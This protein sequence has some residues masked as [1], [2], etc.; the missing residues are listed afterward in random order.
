MRK[1]GVSAIATD[2][3]CKTNTVMRKKKQVDVSV[4]YLFMVNLQPTNQK[5][6]YDKKLLKFTKRGSGRRREINFAKR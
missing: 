1:I 5:G 2:C 6:V 3:I 4:H